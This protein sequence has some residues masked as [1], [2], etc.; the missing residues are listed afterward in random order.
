MTF[1]SRIALATLLPFVVAWGQAGATIYTVGNGA[2]CTHGTI[3][4]AID[5]ADASPGY[6][7]IRLTRSLTYEPE[8]NTV[9][10]D[11][12]LSIVGGFE[13]CTSTDSDGFKTVV[14]GGNVTNAPVFSITANGAAIIKIRLLSITQGNTQNYGGGIYYSGTGNLQ[15]LESDIVNNTAGYGGGIFAAATGS[16][17]ELIISG[18]T[19]ISGN[20]ALYSGGGLLLGGPLE[21]TMTDANTIIAFNQALGVDGITGHGGGMEVIGPAI[22]YL[23]SP[24]S[25]GLPAIYGNSARYGGGISMDSGSSDGADGLV[26]LFTTDPFNPI[27]VQGN[28]ASIHGGGI[29]L[30][31]YDDGFSIAIPTLCALDFRIKDNLA[32]DGSAIYE[33][34]QS[35]AGLGYGADVRLNQCSQSGAVGCA[36]GVECNVISGNGTSTVGGDPTDG[37][38]IRLLGGSDLFASRFQMRGNVGGR[39]IDAEESTVYIDSCLIAD[40]QSSRQLI[41]INS[42]AQTPETR[43]VNC[44]IANNTIASTDVI[45]AIDAFLLHDSII[46]QPGNLALAYSGNLADTDVAYVL[47]SD[48]SSLPDDPTIVAGNPLFVDVA[49]G[50]YHLH[51]SSPAVDFAPSVAGD[52]RDLDGQPRDQDMPGVPDF[53]GNRDLGAYERQQQALDCGAADTVFCDGFEL[54]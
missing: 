52:D 42:G 13:S 37:A 10:T 45:H 24:G 9:V 41:N 27:S 34:Y 44:T 11:Q 22:A 5:A 7:V 51:L 23:G 21:M 17:A 6:D 40:N 15:I 30:Q 53:F 35:I 20:T 18:G 4:S 25:F 32:E 28:T 36:A 54:L 33:D 31:P 49:N 50:D 46:D 26:S 1:T 3:Q 8:A 38:A 29:Y 16:N 48:T 19:T 2:G 12:D 14:S 47:S 39:A 43:I